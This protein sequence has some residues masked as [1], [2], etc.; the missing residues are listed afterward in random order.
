MLASQRNATATMTNATPL[1]FDLPA[2][3]RKKLTVDFDGGNQSSDAGMLLL[4]AAERKTGII[5]R[6]AAALPDRRDPARIRHRFTEI[7]GA[8]VFGICCGYEDAIDHDWLRHD[9]ALK[10]AAGRCPETGAPLASQST[11]SRFEN[12]PS[13]W[14]AGRLSAALVD[15]FTARITPAHRD[16]FDIDDTFDAVHGG[17]QL[18]FWNAH[19]D[20]RGFAPMHVYHAGTGLPVAA[21]LRPAK[22]PNGREVRTV[23]KHLT[24]RL[25]TT[26][27]KADIVWRGDSHYGRA[28]ALDWCD[29]NSVGYI[30]GFPGN[31]VLDA[32]VAE[33]ADHLRFWHVLSDAPKSR[34]YRVLWYQAGSW[35]TPRR[36]IARIEASMHPDPTPGNPDAL[37]QEIDIRY[38]VTSLDGDAE[39]LYEGVYCQRHAGRMPPAWTGREPDQAAQGSA[40]VG[41][42]VVPFGDGQ[43]GAAVAAHGGVLADAHAARRDPRRP[44]ARESRVQH[45]A[46]AVA[47]NRGPRRR[48]RKPHPR[49]P[50][51]ELRR[52]SPVPQP[53]A[54]PLAVRM[55][56]GAAKP[57]TSRRARQINPERVAQRVVARTVHPDRTM[58][59]GRQF[60]P[61]GDGRRA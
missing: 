24:R 56:R 19:H 11:I 15:Q 23:I 49:V 53:R 55:R 35:P 51:V 34:C 54:R 21:I 59:R 26:W 58:A 8:R 17:Q 44:R 27:K 14:D 1:P 3:S 9:P 45:A 40:G 57:R 30:F 5:A 18:A 38:V 7:I 50:A 41:S 42:H 29:D 2:V 16:I 13:R 12:A 6:L 10:M 20:E 32:M 36:V 4:R 60:K 43:S 48:A 25:R 22:T 37:R 52:E 61:R 39:R 31:S 47:E 33:T 28:E 46:S